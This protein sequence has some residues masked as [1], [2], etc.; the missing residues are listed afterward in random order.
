MKSV[1]EGSLEVTDQFVDEM[2]FCLDCQACQTACPAG[3]QYGELVEDARNLISEQGKEPAAVR[4]VKAALLN[5][6]I[7]KRRTKLVARLMRLYQKSGLREAVGESGILSL[8]SERLQMKHALLPMIADEFFDEQIPEIVAVQGER[9]GRVVFLS[10][11]VMNVAFPD[12]HHDAVSLLSKIGYEVVIPKLQECCGSLHGHNG[13]KEEAKR[14]ARKNIEVFEKYEFDALIVDSS[15][16][17]AFLKEYGRLFSDDKVFADRA[18]ALSKKIKDITEFLAG[19][20]MPE[21]KQSISTRVTYHEA[22]HLVHTQKISQQPRNLLQSIPN[23]EFIELP[24]ATWCCGSA[25][26]YN[27]V[28]FDDSMKLLQRKINNLA[29]TGA[30]VVVTANPGCH[31]QLQCGIKN[32]KLKME[33]MHP[34]TLLNRAYSLE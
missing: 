25:G 33:V 8:F 34:V 2:Y 26:I 11:C 18:E 6:L 12:I 3:V 28:R 5:V 21:P 29:V 10:G 23:I 30:D 7:S 13:E 32:F 20:R 17:G 19:M 9:L 16:C 14:L 4:F 15:G 24:E 31:L 1:H 27:V 22:C